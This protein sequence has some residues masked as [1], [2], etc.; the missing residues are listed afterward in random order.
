MAET[1]CPTCG[2]LLPP[3]DVFWHS[4]P[5]ILVA[6]GAYVVLPRREADIFTALFDRKGRVATKSD[7]F[8][9]LYRGGDEPET[10]D[11]VESHVCKLRRKLRALG[12]VLR[13]ERFKGYWLELRRHG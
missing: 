11:V 7:L 6:N 5:G 9:E 12:I 10:E 4:E 1:C 2:Q 13:S 3:D 8:A